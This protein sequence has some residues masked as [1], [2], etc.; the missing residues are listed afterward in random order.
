MSEHLL[1]Q[2][3]SSNRR[4]FASVKLALANLRLFGFDDCAL[5]KERC[6]MS[7]QPVFR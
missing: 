3:V 7:C 1:A 2:I 5:C 6:Y 4:S